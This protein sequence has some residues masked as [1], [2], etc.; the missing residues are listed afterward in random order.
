M[1]LPSPLRRPTLPPPT[2][3]PCTSYSLNITSTTF[4]FRTVTSHARC[5]A[6]AADP[7]FPP[8]FLSHMPLQTLKNILGTSMHLV[9]LRMDGLRSILQPET[10]GTKKTIALCSF[11]ANVEGFRSLYP[12]SGDN[13]V[14][15]LKKADL[16]PHQR[17]IPRN[18]SV[19]SFFLF[20]F[21]YIASSSGPRSPKFC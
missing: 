18:R 6:H 10:A 15:T 8:V 1:T 14:Q 12:L 20:L 9:S 3:P 21:S 7:H 4:T 13:S 19:P 11:P 17:G 5:F 16:K 2:A